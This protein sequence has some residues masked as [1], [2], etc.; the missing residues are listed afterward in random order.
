MRKILY[1][2]LL[3]LFVLFPGSVFALGDITVS[4]GSLTVEQGSSV[5][6]TISA[7]NT[8]GDVSIGSGN[9]NVATVDVNQWSTG[10][11][12]E[13]QTKTGIIT[14][15]WSFIAFIVYDSM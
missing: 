11:V 4:P 15:C 13:K 10:I 14:V 6:F 7:Y 3:A 5:K 2:I 1:S 9:N 12:E 8:I